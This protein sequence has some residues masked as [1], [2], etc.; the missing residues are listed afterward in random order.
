[1]WTVAGSRGVFRGWQVRLC[2]HTGISVGIVSIGK[3]SKNELEDVSVTSLR[4]LWQHFEYTA[5]H[6]C[7]HTHLKKGV[8]DTLHSTMS[9]LWL[10]LNYS[11]DQLQSECFHLWLEAGGADEELTVSWIYFHTRDKGNVRFQPLKIF[12]VTLNCH[13]WTCY[14]SEILFLGVIY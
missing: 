11:S 4:G 9:L 3:N 7:S 2:W 10:A 1:M 12:S 6:I 8:W 5:W 14:K 13:A